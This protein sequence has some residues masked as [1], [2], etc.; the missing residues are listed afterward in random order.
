MVDRQ[1]DSVWCCPQHP[2]IE[3]LI[4]GHARLMGTKPNRKHALA[5]EEI[6]GI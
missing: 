2:E 4:K 6:I 5:T 3:T 1:S